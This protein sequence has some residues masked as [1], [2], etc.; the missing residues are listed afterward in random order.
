MEKMEGRKR[1][2][3]GNGET[4]GLNHLA[5]NWMPL[6]LKNWIFAKITHAV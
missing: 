3:I 5:R 1:D 6:I 2:K 4:I